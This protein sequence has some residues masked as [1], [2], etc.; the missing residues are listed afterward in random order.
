VSSRTPLGAR[1][2]R[3]NA[4][5]LRRVMPKACWSHD[6]L[7]LRPSAARV[8]RRRAPDNDGNPFGA[9]ILAQALSLCFQRQLC[10]RA[11]ALIP[12]GFDID[13]SARPASALSA[14]E[15]GPQMCRFPSPSPLWG[16]P[17]WGWTKSQSL[18]RLVLSADSGLATVATSI[19]LFRQRSQR[20][21]AVTQLA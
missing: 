2:S 3:D 10:R 11:E 12:T 14:R 19:S 7:P 6:R 17:G 13:P 16:G 15:K 20:D 5:R 8:A 9:F 4:P 1:R 21:R 18:G